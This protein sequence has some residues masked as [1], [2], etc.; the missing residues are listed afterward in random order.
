MGKLMPEV[1]FNMSE[2]ARVAECRV[3]YI[4]IQVPFGDLAWIILE[5]FDEVKAPSSSLPPQLANFYIHY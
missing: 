1:E 5:A 4:M 3:A 2:W